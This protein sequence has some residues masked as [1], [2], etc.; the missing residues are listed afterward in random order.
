MTNLGRLEKVELR[1][2]W[3]NEARDFTPWLARE[4]N[5]KL[6]GEVLGIELELDATEKPV[7]S[8]SADILCK[9]TMDDTWVLIEN[10]LDKTD[11]SHL[12]QILTYTAGLEAATI[13][14]I[15]ERF[16]DEHRAALDWLNEKTAEEINFFGLEIELWRI[17]DSPM[18]PKFNIISQ[19]N[20]WAKFVRQ[21]TSGGGEL[22]ELKKTQY[23][24]LSA[25]Q[26]HLETHS[27]TKCSA[28]MARYHWV[29][30]SLGKGGIYIC[31]LASYWDS[32]TGKKGPEVRVDLVFNSPA[33]KEQYARLEGHR[34]EVEKKLEF[35]PQWINPTDAR[36]CRVIV[37]KSVDWLNEETW[38]ECFEWMRIHLEKFKEVFGPIVKTL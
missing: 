14:W 11:H 10:Q 35:T 37:R 5:L 16:T 4:E 33:A 34:I 31:S 26:E 22:S 27:S 30:T 2:A 15:A 32:S 12:G 28:P 36:M 19:P 7:G 13:V 38:P 17:G 3:T 29:T 20:D 8:F 6:L 24:F 23:R 9:N 21:T 1:K 18:A 25:Y